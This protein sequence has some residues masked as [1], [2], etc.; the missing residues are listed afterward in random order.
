MSH[1]KAAKVCEL[2]K[3]LEEVL[4]CVA[5]GKS[6]KEI[7]EALRISVKT[8]RMHRTRLADATG[9]RDTSAL[10]RYA[11]A[12]GYIVPCKVGGGFEFDRAERGEGWKWVRSLRGWVKQ[13]RE[14]R[15]SREAVAAM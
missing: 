7:A 13:N 5:L 3:Q 14:V 12:H 6:D 11:I 1:R 8:V 4:I 2:S 9:K 15:Q 10:T